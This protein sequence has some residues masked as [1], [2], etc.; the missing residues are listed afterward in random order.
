MCFTTKQCGIQQHK[1]K[2]RQNDAFH[3]ADH[4]IA[5]G[6]D[7]IPDNVEHAVPK[8]STFHVMFVTNNKQLELIKLQLVLRVVRCCVNKLGGPTIR[9]KKQ[10]RCA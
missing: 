6:V 4:R 2:L 5:F 3:M 10:Q 1:L 7:V 9:A 8:A